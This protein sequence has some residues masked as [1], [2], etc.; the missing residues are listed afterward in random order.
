MSAMIFLL[1]FV[2]KGFQK[3]PASVVATLLM[4]IPSANVLAKSGSGKITVATQPPGA[5]IYVDGQPSGKTPGTVEELGPG[6]YFVRVEL[7]GFHPE[8]MVVELSNGQAFQAPPIDLTSK[9]TPRRIAPTAAAPAPP[10]VPPSAPPVALATPAPAPVP[11]AT[12]VPAAPVPVAAPAPAPPPPAAPAPAAVATGEEET[13]QKLVTAHLKSIADGDIATYLRLCASKVDLYDEGV[14]G[15]DSIRKSRQKLKDRW[16][17]YEIANVRDLSIRATDKP[18]TRR[19]SVT[20]DWN[21]SNPKTGKQAKGTASD[22]IDFK[23]VGGEWLIVKMRQNV[24]RSKG[25]GQ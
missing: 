20:Y 23:K 17:S 22:S 14:Q 2:R 8:E 9:T 24:D 19:A 11:R 4:A 10:V 16:P 3:V 12:P 6:R 15:H 13:I 18:D 7:D 5:T 25:R 1:Q 21:V